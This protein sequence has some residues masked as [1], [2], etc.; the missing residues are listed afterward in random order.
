M[1]FANQTENGKVID[2]IFLVD[3][4]MRPPRMKNME[5]ISA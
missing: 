2:K 1:I 5:R 4:T 3:G